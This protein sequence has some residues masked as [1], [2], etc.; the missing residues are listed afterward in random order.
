MHLPP[1]VWHWLGCRKV[2]IFLAALPFLAVLAVGGFYHFVNAWGLGKRQEAHAELARRGFSLDSPVPQPG[3]LAAERDFNRLLPEEARQKIQVSD[4]PGLVTSAAVRDETWRGDSEAGRHASALAIRPA[5]AG[6]AEAAREVLEVLAASPLQ[7]RAAM[8]RDALEAAEGIGWTHQ[9]MLPGVWLAKAVDPAMARSLGF[10][11]DRALLHGIAGDPDAAMA[12]LAVPARFLELQRGSGIP[13]MLEWIIAMGLRAHFAEACW[14]LAAMPCSRPEDLARC[15]RWLEQQDEEDR[16]LVHW[17]HELAMVDGFH[18]HM[19]G[20][21][22][23]RKWE[24]MDWSGDWDDP[25]K[26]LPSAGKLLAQFRP[27]GFPNAGHAEFL[28]RIDL[29]LLHDEKG[30]PREQWDRAL[31]RRIES[32]RAASKPGWVSPGDFFLEDFLS[33]AQSIGESVL[34]SMADLR[35]TRLAIAVACHRRERGALPGGLAELVPL[36]LRSLPENPRAA[37][38]FR[39]HKGEGTAAAVVQADFESAAGKL[40][41]EGM[42]EKPVP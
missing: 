8:F 39:L 18:H 9:E 34:V 22:F 4:L 21:F 36:P 10:F 33:S 15:L 41:P 12:D 37:T 16:P 42:L 3:A 32:V 26:W 2:R 25:K 23:A 38:P 29:E 31:Q 40:V 7:E 19:T 20:T 14:Q 27:A 30:T 13:S 11:L 24:E 6:E 28:L 17:R 1:L 35:L 5:A